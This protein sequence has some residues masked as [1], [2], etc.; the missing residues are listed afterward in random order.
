MDEHGHGRRGC[1][2]GRL[3]SFSH[4]QE[5]R[6]IRKTRHPFHGKMRS[7]EPSEPWLDSNLFVTLPMREASA[8]RKTRNQFILCARCCGSCLTGFEGL[9]AKEGGR[10]MTSSMH[11]LIIGGGTAG[12]ALSLFLE[13][14]GISS[15]VSEEHPY[16]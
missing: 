1:A 3:C 13:K 2:C 9:W 8:L 4:L 10:T 15:A 14:A 5:V 6:P 7:H 16:T 11:A 12:P